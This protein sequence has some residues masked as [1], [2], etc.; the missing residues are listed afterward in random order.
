MPPLDP[1]LVTELLRARVEQLP[2]GLALEIP[3]GDGRA[4]FSLDYAQLWSRSGTVAAELRQRLADAGRAPEDEPPVALL[5]GRSSPGLLVC[6][7]ACLRLGVPYLAVDPT[8]PDDH[9]RYLL[10]DA[11]AVLC[12]ADEA[13]VE[14]ATDLGGERRT[15][16]R[17]W[18]EELDGSAG[19]DVGP[20]PPQ[21]LAYLI[22][23]S[24]TTGRP[25][26]VEVEQ[27]SLAN[28]IGEDLEY[29]D[30]G[31]GDRVAQG[32][33]P[34]YDSSLEEVW[35]ALSAGATVVVMDGEVARSGPDLVTWLADEGITVLCPPPTLLRTTGCVDVAAALPE[36]LLVYVGGEALP[37]DLAATWGGGSQGRPGPRLVNGYG[38]TECTVTC[39]R[40][41]VCAPDD[42]RIGLPVRGS[43]A[44][45]LGPD[46]EDLP[47]GESGELWIS[48][49]SLARGYRG[50]PEL[51]AERFPTHPQH[52]RCYRTGDLVRAG[53]HGELYYLGRIDSQVQLR[54]HRVELGAVDARL[55]ELDGVAAAASTVHRRGGRD[56]LVAFL[57]AESP[58]AE[59]DLD[60]LRAQLAATLPEPMVPSALSWIE[61]LPTSV[62]G[63][64]DR[65]G[66]PGPVGPVGSR[67]ELAD[68][69]ARAEGGTLA[70]VIARAFGEVLEL[71]GPPRDDADFFQ[72]LGGDSL[73]AALLV[74][75]LRRTLDLADVAVRDVYAAPTAAGLAL[76]VASANEDHAVSR[77]AQAAAGSQPASRGTTASFGQRFWF[78]SA[79]GLWM[80]GELVFAAAVLG[81]VVLGPGL[82]L[83]EALSPWALLLLS[84]PAGVG[85]G[86]VLA[87][88]MLLVTWLAKR[89]LIGRY[90][91]GRFA[92]FGSFHLRH[93]LVLRLARR[94]PWG[95]VRGT[96][97]TDVFLR[98][99][100]A[101]VG[102]GVHVHRG[103]DLANGGW[104]LLD[105]G[106]GVVLEQD[107]VLRLVQ[108]DAGELVV[109]AVRLG[110][111]AS[112][113]VRAG[114]GPD[115]ELGAGARLGALAC[116]EAGAAVP[117]GETWCGTPAARVDGD[118]AAKYGEARVDVGRSDGVGVEGLGATGARARRARLG[119][120]LGILLGGVVLGALRLLPLLGLLAWAF[121]GSSTEVAS[122]V[123]DAV[124]SIETYLLLGVVLCC[125]LVLDL[126]LVAL[127]VRALGAR[128]ERA[129]DRFPIHGAATGPFVALWLAT[130][131][132]DG[133]GT[134][135]SGS[136]F[137][138]PWLR[139]AGMR[140]GRGAEVSTILDVLPRDITI[141]PE[142]FLADG[143]YLGGAR[144]ERGHVQRAKTRLGRDTF[145]GN[146]AVIVAGAD[147]P[148]ELLIGVCTVAASFPRSGAWFGQPP[149]E[150]PRPSEPE[151][152]RSL[153]HE[154]SLVRRL[155]RLT[156]EAARLGL[157][158]VAA[159]L[160]WLSLSLAYRESG[161]PM[162][163]VGVEADLASAL[164]AI[165]VTGAT[166]V[167]GVL[168][169]KWLLLGR[170]RPGKHALWSCWCSRWD[171]HYVVW[172]LFGRP[173]LAFLD[174]SLL[175][176]FVL[177]L[178]G[179]RIAPGVLLGGGFAQVVDPDML[180]FEAGATVAGVFQAHTFE[181]RVLKIGHLS[182]GPG[183]TL[184]AGAL[185]FYG[186]RL[187]AG[188]RARPQAVALKG[189]LLAAG[190]DHG[191]VPLSPIRR[192]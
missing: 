178:F 159:G 98:V 101:K 167:V 107:A 64:L 7:V 141:G 114:L 84:V 181:D 15:W 105:L 96:R 115:G 132:L 68:Q 43:G 17:D 116:L 166:G 155:N 31:P 165:A 71:G 100:G 184:G 121:D 72:D 172:G 85:L 125:A 54:G 164:A 62:G 175:Q 142:S 161:T 171:F 180:S 145:V 146:H 113:A 35:M 127:V 90:R 75:E 36:L 41:E 168:A 103:V 82:R 94:L 42:V 49:A 5:M 73:A 133:A 111:D 177:R 174:G 80:L 130:G 19:V 137:W 149:I 153:T 60:L 6:Q 139:L 176:S 157:P 118:T 2:A 20:V 87:G 46:G 9:A 169:L 188:S 124:G 190:R 144:L 63:K 126:L 123:S 50:L 58:G 16:A 70:D 102:A 185:A 131:L 128:V 33:S 110:K 10:E 143:I 11:G 119:T 45:V 81:G 25:K 192:S 66:L 48:G 99:L 88:P 47:A 186:V 148:S 170:V 23:T 4:R 78:T 138:P 140:V 162:F 189:E 147:L 89:L 158:M 151:F 120:D 179:M 57:V 13:L 55:A 108:L 74:S 93:W 27:A 152:D 28:L 122:A 91:P 3:A 173:G 18:R 67:A 95:L 104:D 29:F 117:A 83:V 61:A 191:G 97:L 160:A 12:L 129:G 79:Q 53:E 1:P 154:P 32:S 59:P 51:T 65:R 109:G 44:W 24:G 136:L 22:Y 40:S 37:A 156:W 26:G 52:G 187:E 8:L 163:G 86:L 106:D 39:L 92:A 183:A 34:S 56:Q 135:L 182:I 21:R 38:P 30:L 76:R 150:L 77:V 14:R 134:W 69:G 112:V